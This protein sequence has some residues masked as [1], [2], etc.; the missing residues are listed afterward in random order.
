M[1]TEVWATTNYT[2]YGN[3]TGGSFNVSINITI[4]DPIVTLDYTP[5]EFNFTRGIAITLINPTHNSIVDDWELEG[6][7][8]LGLSFNNGQISGTPTVNMTRTTY[9]VWANN[10]GGPASH[11]INITVWEPIVT[12]D[13]NPENITMVRTI[14]MTTL[15]PTVTGGNVETWGIHPSIPAGLNFADGVLSG[16]PTVN[17]TRTTFTIYANTTGGSTTHTVNLHDS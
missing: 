7:L 6:V 12:L 9:T 17:L 14:S 13:Y 10:S 8:P 5:E 3:N 1:P 2:V 11:T 16:T 15:H 4:F